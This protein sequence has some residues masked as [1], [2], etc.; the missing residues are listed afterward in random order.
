MEFAAYDGGQLRA[1][2]SGSPFLAREWQPEEGGLAILAELG[3]QPPA[4][5]VGGSPNHYLDTD[6][7]EA[8]RVAILAATVLRQ[9]FGIA[10]PDQL[11]MGGEAVQITRREVTLSD[12][13]LYLTA[14]LIEDGGLRFDGQRL[15]G[16]S[17]Y[18]YAVMVE[19]ADVPAVVEALGGG[20]DVLALLEMNASKIVRAGVRAW[21]EGLGIE[22]GFWS[23]FGS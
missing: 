12:S 16:D 3:W 5:G 2:V 22:P 10:S 4:D 8:N 23:R 21:L 19:A 13:G 15:S 6:R 20:E 17:E 1:E 18:E 7:G 9:V 14:R 11:A